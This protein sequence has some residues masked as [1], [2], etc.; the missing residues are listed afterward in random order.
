EKFCWTNIRLPTNL[1][2]RSYEVIIYPNLPKFYFRGS[3]KT[4]VFVRRCTNSIVMHVKGLKISRVDVRYKDRNGLLEKEP[5]ISFLLHKFSDL[6]QLQIELCNFL[7]P[8]STV[9]I[10]IS[11]RGVLRNDNFGFY[12]S[13]YT[14]GD[15]VVRYLAATHFQPTEARSA[16]PC[17]DE[18]PMKATFKFYIIRPND[19][20]SLFNTEKVAERAVSS[21]ETMD[22]F[23]TSV[24]MSTYLL[25]F[26]VC[27]FQSKS[28][29]SMS[30]VNISVYSQPS[31]INDVNFALES[32][33]KL[34]DF[35]EGFYGVR[36][37]LKKLG[38][39]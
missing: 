23:N 17:F 27:D 26:V 35:F 15:N 38:G 2:P 13:S 25:A 19:Y 14:T 5:I 24:Q 22:I 3:S 37:P 31:T 30:G 12:S 4:R 21:S 36:Y 18:P 16:I 8:N 32:I 10:E 6:E 34:M 29:M 20:I 39:C 1:I 33:T 7:R 11:F 9:I 28:Q